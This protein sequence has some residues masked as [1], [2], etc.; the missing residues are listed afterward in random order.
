[1]DITATANAINDLPS[2]TRIEYAELRDGILSIHYSGISAAA[3]QKAGWT[4][5]HS[6]DY[7]GVGQIRVD[8]GG[9]GLGLGL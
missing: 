9:S 7:Y 6:T 5:S 3:L 4:H 2:R 8:E 1:M